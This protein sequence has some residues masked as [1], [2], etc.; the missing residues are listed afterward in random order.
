M[1]FDSASAV[2]RGDKG[3]CLVVDALI[4]KTGRGFNQKMTDISSQ[5][6]IGPGYPAKTF[7]AVDNSR[8]LYFRKWIYRFRSLSKLIEMGAFIFENGAG[9]AMAGTDLPAKILEFF[10]LP[11]P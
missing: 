6:R 2:H 5:L 11:L 3:A 10:K 9:L 8:L 4:L 7:H 1:Y